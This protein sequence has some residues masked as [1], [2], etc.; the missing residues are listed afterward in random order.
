MVRRRLGRD[1]SALRALLRGI[2]TSFL[3]HGKIKT[4]AAKAK[5]LVRCASKMITLAKRGDLHAH[6]Q[7]LAFITDKKVAKKLLEEIAPKYVDRNGGYTRIYKL[8]TRRGDC[9]P[10]TFIELV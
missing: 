4:T 3:L 7:I 2:T 9:A 8:G 10:L 6:R 5:E 1:S